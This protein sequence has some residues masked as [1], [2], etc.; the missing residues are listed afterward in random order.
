MRFTFGSIAIIFVAV[1]G[2][3]S[4]GQSASS[5]EDD[6][7][8]GA[9]A[10]AKGR[11]PTER[12]GDCSPV[13]A[14]LAGRV[15]H[16]NW[17]GTSFGDVLVWIAGRSAADRPVTITPH[18]HALHRIGLNEKTPVRLELRGTTVREIL[19]EV[20]DGLAGDDPLV[21]M[22]A[23]GQLEITTESDM[24]SELVTVAYDIGDL[25]VEIPDERII[26]EGIDTRFLCVRT[27]FGRR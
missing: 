26:T 6:P 5:Q 14:L 13:A 15:D 1:F 8:R 18:W 22:A 16:V 7:R 9:S 4:R 21:Y 23:G 24:R 3:T 20:L 25:L 11:P 27:M 19:S 2:S 12:G 10:R 17:D